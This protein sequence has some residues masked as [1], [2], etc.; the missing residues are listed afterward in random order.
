VI[1]KKLYKM[2]DS[3]LRLFQGEVFSIDLLMLYLSQSQAGAHVYLANL[4]YQFR[5]EQV[6]PFVPQLLHLALNATDAQP[7][8]RFLL[9]TCTTSSKFA[10][11]LY[12]LCVTAAAEQLFHQKA[13]V[14]QL[15]RDCEYTIVNGARPP[16]TSDF[17]PPHLFQVNLPEA[18]EYLRHH[19]EVRAELFTISIQLA[20]AL[21]EVSINLASHDASARN[22]VLKASL[23]SISRWLI[24]ER[25]HYSVE[26]SEYS[27]RLFRGA[28]LPVDFYDKT[29]TEQFISIFPGESF[30]YFTR[31]RVPYC[32]IAE[33][34]EINDSADQCFSIVIHPD[35]DSI[36][37][38][39]A[40]HTELV[41]PWGE[42]WAEMSRRLAKRSRYSHLSTW[43]VRG[44]IVKGLDDLRQEYLAI[45]FIRTAKLILADSRAKL[46]LRPYDILVISQNS[47]LIELVPDALSL[48][49]LKK[50]CPDWTSLRDFFQR[51]LDLPF[52]DAQGNFVESLA[53]YSLVCYLLNLK[54]RHNGNILLDRLGHVI[55][56]DYGYMLT[57]SP[58][59]N[60]GFETAP[61]KLTD[62]MLEVMDGE[63]SQMFSYFKVLFFQ[64][65]LALRKHIDKLLLPIE[66]MHSGESLPCFKDPK[67]IRKLK[68]R[69]LLGLSDSAVYFKVESLVSSAASSW[70]TQ[71]YDS[72]QRYSNGIL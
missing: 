19:K 29:G 15:M 2:S 45:Q 37:L 24:D 54:D 25:I 12:W 71:K 38:E 46:W 60:I 43:R 69:F 70:T 63:D 50:N 49:A 27:Q 56:I 42:S 7:L 14:A 35:L 39:V 47:G 58:G 20:T 4:L 33:T 10:L 61:F 68:K 72:Y 67:A 1:G 11:K 36:D 8:S 48:D 23:G 53:G 13:T 26:A 3:L 31:E 34:V 6:D 5:I 55:H 51:Y 9:D 17:E 44:V 18:P 32:L 30:C 41:Q 52:D 57:N 64:G 62:E 28:Y 66:V 59:K 40:S 21:C 65:L 16:N 22:S